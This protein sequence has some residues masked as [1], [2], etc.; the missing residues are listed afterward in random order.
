MLL[1]RLMRF[2]GIAAMVVLLP[3]CSL[4]AVGASFATPRYDVV[5]VAQRGDAVH[6]EMED[7]ST[8]VGAAVEVDAKSVTVLSGKRDFVL[9]YAHIKK[10]SRR[11]GWGADLVPLLIAGLIV[12]SAALG[13][14]IAGATV[15]H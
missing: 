3:G 13:C 4:L 5:P 7:G 10:I 11:H 14:I 9:T 2:L 12:D 8:V 1:L 6:V 15:S